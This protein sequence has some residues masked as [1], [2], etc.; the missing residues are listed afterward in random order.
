MSSFIGLFLLV[1]FAFL[2][3]VGFFILA[4]Y[5]LFPHFETGEYLLGFLLQCWVKGGWKHS[6]ACLLQAKKKRN[7]VIVFSDFVAVYTFLMLCLANDSSGHSARLFQ[8]ACFLCE[9]LCCLFLSHYMNFFFLP[10]IVAVCTSFFFIIS[11]LLYVIEAWAYQGILSKYF[12]QDA[13]HAEVLLFLSLSFSFFLFWLMVL[14]L[15][16]C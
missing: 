9:D 10:F 15:K 1:W 14:K 12:V 4:F 8:H 2:L 11:C 3:Y 5:F 13:C 16:S 6:K 7:R